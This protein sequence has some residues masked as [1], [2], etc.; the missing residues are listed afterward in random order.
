MRSDALAGVGVG[1][2]SGVALVAGAAARGTTRAGGVGRLDRE[3]DAGP[4]GFGGVREVAG[5]LAAGCVDDLVGGGVRS[6]NAATV[7]PTTATQAIRMKMR[8]RRRSSSRTISSRP[9]G[10]N[11]VRAHS[12]HIPASFVTVFMFRDVTGHGH[13][14]SFAF[15][16]PMPTG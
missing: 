1:A 5:A 9:A 7:P 13:L 2:G 12:S 14:G 4:L 16:A 6:R 10:S 8:M 3:A 11:R 15:D